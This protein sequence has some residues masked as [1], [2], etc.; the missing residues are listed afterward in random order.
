[1][2]MTSAVA[3][4]THAVSPVSSAKFR[5]PPNPISA[6]ISTGRITLRS[7]RGICHGV[8]RRAPPAFRSGLREQLDP[9]AVRIL[10]VR[11]SA[12]RGLHLEHHRMAPPPPSSPAGDPP[13]GYFAHPPRLSDRLSVTAPFEFPSA[14]SMSALRLVALSPSTP[15]G[16]PAFFPPGAALWGG[17]GGPPRGCPR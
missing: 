2:I 13:W 4:M 12:P 15:G 7:P 3:A 17:R 8:I 6:G 5:S 10:D 16:G 11:P 9:D 1:M 14:S